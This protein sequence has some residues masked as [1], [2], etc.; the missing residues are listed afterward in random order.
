VRK[1][2]K[3]ER[4]NAKRAAKR[5]KEGVRNCTTLGWAAAVKR[6]TLTGRVKNVFDFFQ[7][8]HQ[9]IELKVVRAE[10]GFLPVRGP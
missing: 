8:L 7:S 9:S 4:S 2:D 3:S 6:K 5:G 10:V 1:I